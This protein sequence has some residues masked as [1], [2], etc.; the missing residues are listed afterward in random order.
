MC[1]LKPGL[2]SKITR[3]FVLLHQ[4]LG[5]SKVR[6][7]N[8][9]TAWSSYKP[10]EIHGGGSVKMPDRGAS[11]DGPVPGGPGVGEPRQVVASLTGQSVPQV[12]AGGGLLPA[13]G[14]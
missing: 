9:I 2:S 3:I 5:S 7:Y 13:H 14:E 1:F 4:R 11:L 10:L 12:T 6:I 8:P